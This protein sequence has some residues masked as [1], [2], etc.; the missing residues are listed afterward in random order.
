MTNFSI[1]GRLTS[2]LPQSRLIG[3]ATRKKSPRRMLLH[4]LLALLCAGCGPSLEDSVE[5]LGGSPEERAQARQD[6]LL[7][8]DRSVEPLLDALRD[9]HFKEAH[10]ELVDVLVSLMMRVADARIEQALRQL[11][12]ADPDP[13]VRARV[14]RQLGLF[15]RHGAIDALLEATKDTHGEV[16]FQALQALGS[17]EDKIDEVQQETLRE[18]S[19]VLLL[20]AHPGVRMEATI[21]VEDFVDQWIDDAR[22]QQLK[23]EL[24]QAESL[25]SKALAYSPDS[26]QGNYRLGRFYLD[27]GQ[28]E[29]GL[30]LL[31]QHGMLLDVPRLS[32]PPEIDGRLDEAVWQ[33]TARVDSFFQLSKVHQAALPSETRTKFFVG[34]TPQALYVGFI[35]HDAHPDSL[36]V[37]VKGFDDMTYGSWSEDRLEL[38]VDAD[39]DHRTYMQMSINSQGTV[40]DAWHRRGLADYDTQWNAPAQAAAHVGA[41]FW[42]AEYRLAF[43]PEHNPPPRPGTLWGFNFVRTFRGSEFSQ[44]VR[45]YGVNAH[46]P[47]D[48]GLLRFE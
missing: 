20:D 3:T 43:D 27:N 38:F 44:W 46:S 29:K 18:R 4:T 8:K 36:V 7:A 1:R 14:A 30:S 35:G 9:P 28:P 32:H 25:Y 13:R 40:V 16:R 17:M 34:Y 26:K 10:P 2:H 6:L 11:L 24:A 45:T 33:E 41:D 15:K 23:A 5:K 31:R 19:R 37:G 42:S 48:F 12:D 21:R 39:F 47:D 22:Q